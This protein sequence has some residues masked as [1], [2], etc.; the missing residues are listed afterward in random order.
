VAKYDHQRQFALAMGADELVDVRGSVKQRYA[1]WAKSLGADLIKPELGKPTVMGGADIIFDCVASSTTIDDGLRFTKSAGTFVLVGMPGVPKGVDWTPMWFKELTVLAAYAYG[2][3]RCA[4]G[5]RDTFDIAIEYMKT[6][7]S[8]LVQLVS[9]PFSLSDYRSAIRS[10][11]L[12]GQSR[13][14]KTV[15]EIDV[16]T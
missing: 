2:P 14:V 9:S 10:A 11:L 8:K 3:E 15:F 4:D 1:V 16:E 12:T 13:V 6:W 7:R 5:Q